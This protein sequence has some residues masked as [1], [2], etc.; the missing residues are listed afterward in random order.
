MH[1]ELLRCRMTKIRG[2]DAIRSF[3]LFPSGIFDINIRNIN[4]IKCI[5]MYKEQLLEVLIYS[6]RG[7][8]LANE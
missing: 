5:F 6:L 7:I 2:S 4:V 1:L 8:Y 3:R